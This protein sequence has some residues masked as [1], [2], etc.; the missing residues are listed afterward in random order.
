MKIKNK[1]II[2][3]NLIFLILIL[4]PLI[5][6]YDLDGD[7]IDDGE[8]NLCGDNF[9]QPNENAVNCPAD[10]RNPLSLPTTPPSNSETENKNESIKNSLSPDTGKNQPK[11]KAS[12]LINTLKIILVLVSFIMVITIIY[13][14]IKKSKQKK[15]EIQ[16]LG[17]QEVSNSQ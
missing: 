1:K 3:V 16:N 10:C 15:L 14:L 2:S 5:A 17:N 12:S 13:F 4:I 6:G 8:Q 9:C 11:E 7:G